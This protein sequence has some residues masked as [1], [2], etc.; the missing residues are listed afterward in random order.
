[1]RLEG[2]EARLAGVLEDW[3][4][5]EIEWSTSDCSN[6]VCDVT[7]ALTGEPDR[8]GEFRGRY[9]DAETAREIIEGL[10]FASLADLIASRWPEIPPAFAHRGDIGFMP[11]IGEMA[12]CVVM[13]PTVLGVVENGRG[14]SA[15][16]REKM[17]RAFRVG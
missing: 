13:G 9:Y 14:L 7:A 4:D 10:G 12:L 11:E 6:L 1:M 3:R 2:W 8:L 5:R 16:P 15:Y 17:T